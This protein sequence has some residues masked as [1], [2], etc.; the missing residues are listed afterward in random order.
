[1]HGADGAAAI[2]GADGFAD[3]DGADGPLAAEAEAL[4]AADDEELI[5]GVGE[6]AEEGEEGEPEDG[7]AED[8]DASEAVGGEAGEPAA[9][10]GEQQ[11]GGAE[12]AGLAFA[13]V[14]EQHQRR[15]HE[16]VDHDVDAIEHP[17]GE[18]GDEGGALFG[19]EMEEPELRVA[20]CGAWLA[21]VECLS[22]SGLSRLG[23]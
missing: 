16:A 18:G 19:V 3:E 12:Q 10:R 15:E 21:H 22:W 4:Q 9:D 14:P 20:G 17:A 1:M 11:R 13:D 2:F 6:A 8:A 5:E 23:R 7:E